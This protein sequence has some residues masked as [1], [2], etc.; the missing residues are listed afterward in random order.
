MKTTNEH[1]TF[2]F[3]HEL[4]FR[5]GDKDVR[6]KAIDELAALTAVRM[7]QQRRNFGGHVEHDQNSSGT[8]HDSSP[9]TQNNP[10]PPGGPS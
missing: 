8:V 4:W 1:L 10:E 3:V 2:T 9:S 5:K 6:T 7:V